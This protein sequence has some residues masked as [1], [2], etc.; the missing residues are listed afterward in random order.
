MDFIAIDFE[1]ANNNYNS[2]C[3]LGLVMVKNNKIVDSKYYLIQPPTLKFNPKNIEI[4]G[5]SPDDVRDKPKFPKV[6]KEISQYFDNTNYVVAHNARFDM[7]VLK[8]CLKDYNLNIPDFKY[9]CSMVISGKAVRKLGYYAKDYRTL[10]DISKLFNIELNHHNALSDAN[11][12]AQIVLKTLDVTN[13]KSINTFLSTY[14]SVKVRSFMDLKVKNRYFGKGQRFNHIKISEIK[15][16]NENFDTDHPF[17]NK[18]FVFTGELE[19]ISRRDAMQ[20]IVDIGGIVK[21]GVSSKTDYLVVGKQD[22]T[23]VGEDGLS[24]KERKAY[25]LIDKGLDIKIL[26]E[27]DFLKLLKLEKGFA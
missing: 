11:A 8:I 14:R 4:H 18:N 25:K 19:N 7:S 27:H 26:N 3:A 24:T 23:I 5:I 17:Y 1:T 9:V 13:R 12:C 21:S 10:D 20:R 22:L 6:W 2:A 15:T 16:E